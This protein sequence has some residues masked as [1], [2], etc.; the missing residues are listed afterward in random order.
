M[1]QTK[2]YDVVIVGAGLAG[3]IMA[4]K[5]GQEGKK[6]LIIE[7]GASVPTSREDYMEQFYTNLIKTPESPYPN[8]PNAPRATVVDLFGNWKD[9]QGR[10]LDQSTSPL[11]FSSTYERRGG[12]TMWHWLGSSFRFVPNDFKLQTK[13][14]QGIDWPIDYEDLGLPQPGRTSAYY[15][16]AENEIG[17]AADV[18]HQAYLGLSFTPGYQYPNP[19]IP[20]TLTDELFVG[21][22]NGKQQFEGQPVTVYPTPAGR[23]S[24]PY[25]GRRVC[26]GNTNCIPICPI[27][28]KYDPT[29][30]LNKALD[31]T[32]AA[33][34]RNVD[35]MYQTV[36][37]KVK[38]D[39]DN[40]MVVGIECITYDNLEKPSPT[41]T[42]VVTGTTYVIAG[43]AIETPKLLLNSNE[44][45]PKGVANSSG[46]VGKNLMD[47]PLYLRWGLTKDPTFPYR[48]PLATAGIESLRDGPFRDKRAAFRVEFGNEGWNFAALDPETTVLDFVDGTNKNQ[49][50]PNQEK[51]FGAALLNKLNEVFTRQFRFGFL[52]EQSP[53]DS[54]SVTPSTLKDAL[55]IPRPKINYNLSDYTK[56]AFVA[57]KKLTDQVFA[58]A[59]V[60]PFQKTLSQLEGDAGYFKY[61]DPDTNQTYNF[62]YFGSGHIVGTYRMGPTKECSVVDR[63]QRSWDHPNLFLVGSGVF[64]TIATGNPSLTIAAL[65]FW[66][67]DNVLKDL[68]AA[69]AVS[70]S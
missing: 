42:I 32:D 11:P 10:Y 58:A 66:A 26:A 35:V 67:A 43:H 50:N 44:Q 25:D 37:S 6:V 7:S 13:Y 39:Q 69:S 61:T 63:N 28:A 41:G 1:A 2:T 60:T 51:L 36:A 46:Q 22:L 14:R 18:A 4:Y 15:D 52:I 9:P 68:Q 33:G 48:G 5:L 59:G 3:S 47:H 24:R 20:L 65:A 70:S 55:G 29:I 30:T 27:Q 54:N 21:V 16:D 49:N 38:L 64:P 40:K 17:V 53:E 8:N 12:G 56:Q 23:N 57:A 62:E 31:T 45:L 19:E 34:E